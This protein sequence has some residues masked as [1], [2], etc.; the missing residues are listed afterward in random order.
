MIKK[1]ISMSY[2]IVSY[3]LFLSVFTYTILFVGNIWVTPSLDTVAD[4]NLVKALLLDL[5]LLTAFALQHSIMARPG[6]KRL[7]TK[8]VPAH[9]ERS[10][11]VLFSTVLLGALVHYWQPLG[12]VIWQ[13]TDPFASAVIHVV[14]V[15]GWAIMLL[16][17]FQLNHFDLFGLRQAWLYAQGK[18]YTQLPFKKPILYRYMRHPLYVGMMIGL[19]AAPTM[20]VAHLFFALMS[21]G[22][23]IVG[24]MLEERDLER[25]LPEYSQYR[26]EVS[27][28]IPKVRAA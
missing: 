22:Y 14:F 11:Y 8:V 12:G 19:W 5:G 3:A 18:P 10:T 7:W 15:L 28:F 9:L 4:V 1:V 17:T 27:R 2:S 13:I 23:I 21:T 26:R 24:S 25:A 6:F 20:T 16:S